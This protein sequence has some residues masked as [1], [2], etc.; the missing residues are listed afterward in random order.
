MVR[1]KRKWGEAAVAHEERMRILPGAKKAVLMMHGIAGT[2]DHFRTI[3]PLEDLVPETWSL[4]NVVMPGHGGRVEDFSHSSL[5]AWEA[6]CMALFERLCESHE[7]V[8][9]VGHS[10]GTLFAIR[11]AHKRP[12]KVAAMLLIEVPLRVG[13]KLFTIRNLI[14]FAFGRLDLTDPVQE[15]TSRV[16][17]I[18]PTWMVW[19]YIGWLPRV[20]EL[21]KYMHQTDDLLPHL[22]V[23]A[24]AYQSMRDEMVSDRS[25][26]LLLQAET[27]QVRVFSKSTHFYCHPEDIARVRDVFTEQLAHGEKC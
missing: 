4:C 14:R 13:V 24:V 5:P 9:L 18:A 20:A 17:S 21:V 19:K 10:M 2:P 11:M 6:Y 3:L 1:Y 12:E 26:K 27:V 16:C 8:F 23:P 25:R 22:T 7:Q 15:A